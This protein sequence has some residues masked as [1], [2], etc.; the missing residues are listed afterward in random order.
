MS[1]SF[2]RSREARAYLPADGAY[3]AVAAPLK[4]RALAG[5]IDW[6]AVIACYLV[7][8]IPLGMI[9]TVSR[10]VGGAA[11][12]AIFVVT[13]AA[14]LAVVAGYFAFFL[15]TGSTLG[16]R[17]LDIH[18]VAYGS[19]RPPGLLPSI[20]R[21]LLAVAFFLAAFTAYAYVFGRYEPGLS[22]FEETTRVASISITLV[23]LT[24]HLWKLVDEAG[25]SLWDRVSGLIVVE[26]MIP[27]TMPDRLWSPW[28]T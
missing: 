6:V 15:H 2:G 12:T 26:E 23:A 28:G 19:G 16:M 4:R 3:R 1:V 21:S 22:N 25:R 9:E 5:L 7:A 24:G 10:E 14:G 20:W 17:A 18:V 27:T 11:E 13:Q 8:N